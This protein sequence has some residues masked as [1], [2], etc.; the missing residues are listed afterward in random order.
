M[1]KSK[2]KIVTEDHVNEA[3]TLYL[4]GLS[5]ID[6]NEIVTAT[7]GQNDHKDDPIYLLTIEEMI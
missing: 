3:L 6:D 2:Q 4:R 5:I 7:H 1:K